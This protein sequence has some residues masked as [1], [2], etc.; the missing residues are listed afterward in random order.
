LESLRKIALA[1]AATLV[2]LGGA[3]CACE[4]V[5]QSACGVPGVERLAH[6]AHEQH[7][8]AAPG[9]IDEGPTDDAAACSHCSQ[10]ALA[11]SADDGVMA[12]TV[13]TH[14][15]KAAV[16]ANALVV[17]KFARREVAPVRI[18]WRAPPSATPV[19][20]KIRLRN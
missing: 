18:R 4:S 3:A 13:K 10:T 14:I 11:Q 17:P 2:G 1:L 7:A 6:A 5:A 19:A 12:P 9:P 15:I 8:S 16:A 20:L